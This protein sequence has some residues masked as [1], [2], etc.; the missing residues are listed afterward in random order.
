M[1]TLKLVRALE[2]E[3]MDTEQAAIIATELYRLYAH[4]VLGGVYKPVDYGDS[5]KLTLKAKLMK[6]KTEAMNNV[7]RAM[8][9][10]D[11]DEEKHWQSEI[12][13]IDAERRQHGF[14]K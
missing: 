1:D 6:A 10:N 4:S 5:E 3:G 9:A 13:R 11:A 8:H 7:L 2:G 12:E 14:I